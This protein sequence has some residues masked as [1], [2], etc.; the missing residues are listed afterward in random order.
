[1]SRALSP[2]FFCVGID[3]KLDLRKESDPLNGV[4]LGTWDVQERGL[5]LFPHFDAIL[6]LSVHHQWFRDGDDSVAI[7]TVQQIARTAV[8][9]MY[10]EFPSVSVKYGLPP[11]SLFEDNNPMSVEAYALDWCRRA[12][13]DSPVRAIGTIA[14]TSAEPC[15]LTVEI[16][17]STAGEK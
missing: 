1:M 9:R 2:E 8:K 4:A 15:R 12:F 6:L 10:I 14:D 13:P 11:G 5:S 7:A 16:D 17:L 3:R